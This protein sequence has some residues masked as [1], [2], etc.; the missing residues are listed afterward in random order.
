M[1]YNAE[2]P[3]PHVSPRE[4]LAYVHQETHS[5]AHNGTVLKVKNEKRPNE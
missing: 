2:I 4:S 3:L 5:T 1:P